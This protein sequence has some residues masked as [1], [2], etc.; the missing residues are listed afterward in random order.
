MLRHIH[1]GVWA[2]K[3]E[4]GE[5]RGGARDAHAP[6]SNRKLG[7]DAREETRRAGWIRSR[8]WRVRGREGAPASPRSV[9]SSGPHRPEGPWRIAGMGR[10]GNAARLSFSLKGRRAS[11]ARALFSRHGRPAPG[12]KARPG[13][14]RDN[15]CWACSACRCFQAGTRDS[16]NS[17]TGSSSE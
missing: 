16:R 15:R 8:S 2:L 7:N 13:R 14:K 11:G 6:M 9:A 5:E 10:A 3:G 12:E 1:R 4:D 17:S